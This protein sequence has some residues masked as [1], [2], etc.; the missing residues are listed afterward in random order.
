MEDTSDSGCIARAIG[1]VR[2]RGNAVKIS[3]SNNNRYINFAILS[4]KKFNSLYVSVLG[5]S[6]DKGVGGIRRPCSTG[7]RCGDAVAFTGEGA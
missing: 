1:H 2:A 3:L 5:C 6:Y 7:I 4:E